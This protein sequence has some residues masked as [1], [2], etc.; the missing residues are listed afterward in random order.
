MREIKIKGK[1]PSMVIIGPSNKKKVFIWYGMNR[2]NEFELGSIT[3]NDMYD[4]KMILTNNMNGG[5]FQLKE[6]NIDKEFSSIA[7]VISRKSYN[8]DDDFTR[9]FKDIFG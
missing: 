8:Q 9:L 2:N 7:K 4:A 1:N 5:T 3:A 6:A